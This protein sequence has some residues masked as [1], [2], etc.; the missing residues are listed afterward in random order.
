MPQTVISATPGSRAILA[1]SGFRRLLAVRLSSQLA[2]G[3]FQAGLAGSIL[4]NPNQKTSPVEIAMGFAVLLLPYSILGPYVGVLLDRWDRRASLSVANL[5]RAFFVIPVAILLWHGSHDLWFAVSALMVIAIN[6][7]VLAGYSA[8]LPRVVADEKL[9]PANA[10]AA[11]L[12]TVCYSIGLFSSTAIVGLNLIGAGEH[13]YGL[14][15][16]GGAVGYAAAGV[17]AWTMFRREELGPLEH[18]KH[19]GKLSRAVVEVAQ[20]MVAGGKHLYGKR[21]ALRAMTLQALYRGLYGVLTLATLLLFSQY[22]GHNASAAQSLGDLGIVVIAGA[23][24]A[25]LAAV[26][27]PPAVRRFGPGRWLTGLV[28]AVGLVVLVCGLPFAKIPLVAAAFLINVAS[29]SMKIIVDATIQHECEDTYR[30]RI[31]SINDTAF[32]MFFVCGLFVAATTFPA[33]GKSVAGLLSVALG[34]M[35]LSAWYAYI[36]SRTEAAPVTTS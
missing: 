15:S 36:R 17:L 3:F 28:F 33:N 12:G 19:T 13:G 14:I 10:L 7:F 25:A 27:T 2:D 35:A 5:A 31:F 16:A 6:R 1:S 22:F 24:G 32:N 26:V 8:A 20:G 4:F 9:V 30:G 21:K 34:F 29:Q 18:E 23:A 11:T